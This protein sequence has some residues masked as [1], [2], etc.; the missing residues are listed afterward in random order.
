MHK[1]S[2]QTELKVFTGLFCLYIDGLL[3]ELSEAGVGC[4]IGNN[5][6]G[7][8]AY[9]DDL[10]SLAPSASAMR[11]MLHI[12]EEYAVEYSITFNAN[13]SKCIVFNSHRSF[14]FGSACPHFFVDN[15]QIYFVDSWPHLGM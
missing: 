7:A 13:K 10:T 14:S 4:F 11:K 12:C 15:E 8:L 1:N 5:F 3:K 2:H 9:A 6:V